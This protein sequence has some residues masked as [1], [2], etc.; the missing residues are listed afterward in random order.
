MKAKS[1]SKLEP[2]LRNEALSSLDQPDASINI[3]EKPIK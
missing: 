1:D 3:R 2:F